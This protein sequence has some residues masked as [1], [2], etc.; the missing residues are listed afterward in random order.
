MKHLTFFLF[1]FAVYLVEF[2]PQNHSLDMEIV[3]DPLGLPDGWTMQAHPSVIIKIDSLTKYSGKFSVMFEAT[4]TTS[5]NQVGRIEYT[6]PINHQGERITLKAYIKTED[7]TQPFWLY[8]AALNEIPPFLEYILD[9][10]NEI[11]DID[12]NGTNDWKEYSISIPLPDETKIIRLGVFFRGEG[13]LWA[14]DFRV[15]VDDKELFEAKRKNEKEKPYFNLGMERVSETLKVPYG[16]WKWGNVSIDSITKHSG[17][18]SLLLETGDSVSYGQSWAWYVFPAK[19][20]GSKIKIN[21]YMKM[22]DNEHPVGLVIEARNRFT[23]ILREY[24]TIQG[25]NDWKKYSLTTIIPSSANSFSIGAYLNGEG[26]LWIDDFEI[27]IDGKKLSKAK[28]KNIESNYDS[29]FDTESKIIISDYTPQMVNNLEILCRVWGFMKYYHPAIV[30]GKYNWDAELFRIMPLIL[31]ATDKDETNKILSEWVDSFSIIGYEKSNDK[32]PQH[33]VKIYP[34]L[35]W[36]NNE[37]LSPDLAEKLLKIRDLERQKDG[38]YASLF[39]IVP[40][41]EFKNENPYSFMN[42]ED[43]GLRLLALFRYWNMIQYFFPYKH[44]TDKDWNVILAEF[45]PKFLDANNEIDYK[46]TI[47]QLA[48]DVCDGHAGFYD[49]TILKHKG[50]NK[51][52]YN[53]S[54]IEGKAVVVDNLRNDTILIKGDIIKSIDG[55]NVESIIEEKM[56]YAPASNIQGK[57]NLIATE[58]LNTNSENL[59]LEILR[60]DI[61]FTKQVKCFPSDSLPN[62]PDETEAYSFMTSDIGYIYPGTLDRNDFKIVPKIMKQFRKTKGIIIDLR[63]YPTQ[64]IAHSIGA[65]LMS[66]PTEYVKFTYGSI[67]SPGLFV[68]ADKKSE[69][70]K[71]GKISKVGNRFKFKYKGTVVIIVNETTISQAEFTAMAFQQA[72]RAIVIGSTTAGADGNVSFS[73]Y[74]P[75]RIETQISG[76][77]VYY[78]DGT[79]TQRTGIIIDKEVKP[80]IRG[81]IEGRD[82]VL[83]KAIEIIENIEKF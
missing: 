41:P 18:Y 37:T 33:T 30:E 12:F 6:I 66:K 7:N 69:M 73:I 28:L 77:G 60:N 44:L 68:F 56:K 75:G 59:I 9:V 72:R 2:F 26:K 16:W 1:F 70:P 49:R 45:I 53:I 5:T 42:F 24:S 25:S 10:P 38:Y 15:F 29:E 39:K 62:K 52:P 46:M 65:H 64:W 71:V 20:K 76:I 58:L 80:T 47:L 51:A 57:L 27:F 43:A 79:E 31:N 40:I 74:L 82:E 63:C 19:Y 23:S 81:I 14:D 32:V 35:K 83:E 78:P 21:A 4:D 8:F 3:S 22:E 67:T 50:L 36:L 48:T 11:R 55:R 13:K 54:F 61:L 17:K 34:D